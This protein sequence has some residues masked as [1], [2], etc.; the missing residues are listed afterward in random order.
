MRRLCRRWHASVWRS[1]TF[2]GELRRQVVFADIVPRTETGKALKHLLR[3]QFSVDRLVR[4]P[5]L[6][7]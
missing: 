4:C 6:D 2:L 7:T 5:W 3:E 1:V